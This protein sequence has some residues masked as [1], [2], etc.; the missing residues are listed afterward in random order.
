MPKFFGQMGRTFEIQKYKN[1]V[2][3]P[4]EPVF[5]KN[6]RHGKPGTVFTDH[7]IYKAHNKN[8]KQGIGEDNDI[9]IP[10]I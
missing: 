10:C 8:H 6:Q 7:F 1:P 3:F 9:K 4:G 2:F 5:A